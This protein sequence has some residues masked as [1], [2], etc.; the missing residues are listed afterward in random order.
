[1]NMDTGSRRLGAAEAARVACG[2]ALTV[3]AAAFLTG[4][5]N[6]SLHRAAATQAQPTSTAE[7][8]TRDWNHP[9]Y[10]DFLPT[11]LPE[12][13]AS[14]PFAIT[15]PPG[16]GSTNIFISPVGTPKT[17][18][19]VVFVV[20]D[21]GW[22]TYW[23]IESLP[24]IPDPN[25]RVAGWNARVSEN[26][27]PGWHSTAEVIKLSDGTEVL[28]GT[29]GDGLGTGEFVVGDVQFAVIGERITPQQVETVADGLAA[30]AD[31]KTPDSA[32]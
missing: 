3:A 12:A 17:L 23:V 4:C 6:R 28:L 20:R 15:P 16:G 13:T 29:Y 22:G 5:A 31:G 18:L 30:A 32:A 9:I 26:G 19:A 27:Q 11:D 21:E 7:G 2:I 1:M 10:G 14:V 8:P 25:Q 24:D